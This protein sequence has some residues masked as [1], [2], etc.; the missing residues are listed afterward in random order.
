MTNFADI[1]L[2]CDFCNHDSALL[3]SCSVDLNDVQMKGSYQYFSVCSP[4]Y[5][6]HRRQFVTVLLY[7]RNHLP[8]I[9]TR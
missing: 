6:W 9:S 1:F 7:W 8:E 4:D 2:C 5:S 3:E